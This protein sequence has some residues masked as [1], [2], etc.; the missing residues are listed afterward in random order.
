MRT[1]KSNLLDVYKGQH[2]KIFFL[3]PH[4]H[5]TELLLQLHQINSNNLKW[6]MIFL[7]KLIF[8][9]RFND[10]RGELKLSFWNILT[11]LYNSYCL[12]LHSGI[13]TK[14]APCLLTIVF[15]PISLASDHNWP[16][17]KERIDQL[18][19]QTSLIKGNF[20]SP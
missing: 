13:Q 5:V 6:W 11:H 3:T 12:S 7:M 15:T 17:L 8:N 19:R 4:T 2:E 10:R 9:G 20:R 14:T 18:I 16:L 1:G